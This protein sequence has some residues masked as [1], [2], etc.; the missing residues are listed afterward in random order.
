M[1][2]RF[3]L[4][5][6]GVK[7]TE[8]PRTITE[9]YVFKGSAVWVYVRAY[10]ISATPRIKY[11]LFRQDI[12]IESKGH[13]LWYITIP[14]GPVPLPE[15]SVVDFSWEFDT[16]G[17]VARIKHA[18]Q[19]IADYGRALETPPNHQ[20]AIE[21]NQDGN[22]EGCDIVVPAFKW[23]ENWNLPWGDFGWAYSSLVEELTGKVNSAPFR[24]RDAGTVRFD[25]GVGARS[26][27]DPDSLRISFHFIASRNAT[28]L[29][30]G[31]GDITG[32][33]KEGWQY[34]WVESHKEEDTA[35][36][37]TV[38]RPIAAHVERVY[39]SASFAVLG[40]GS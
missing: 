34:L 22:V 25:G 40:I 12:Q 10:V 5:H 4:K 38:T 29:T 32:I 26:R 19:H 37:R 33:A 18:K 7:S 30:V 15:P 6:K 39:D 9:Q 21:V 13:D 1:S 20:G 36:G 17:G 24:G 28:A 35:A 27:Q 23:R 3:Y 14:Y 8:D 31:D 2:I 11:G 16:T